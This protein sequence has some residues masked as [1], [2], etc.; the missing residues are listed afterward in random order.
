M[1][2]YRVRSSTGDTAEV[3]EISKGHFYLSFAGNGQIISPIVDAELV[4]GQ[5]T[6]LSYPNYFAKHSLTEIENTQQIT[7][8]KVPCGFS[9]YAKQLE[10]EET[11]TI[12]TMI[13]H[14]SDIEIINRQKDILAT[15]E[16]F[17][18]KYQEA[19]ELV[20]DITKG[21]ETKTGVP[22]FDAYT[23]QSYLDNILRGGYPIFLSDNE[24]PFVYYVYSRK[25]GDLERDYNFFFISPEFFSQGN[26][27]FRD[28]N[29]N[30]RNDNFFNPK[31]GN[32]NI[33]LFMN[34]IQADGY[35][36][37]VVKGASFEIMNKAGLVLAF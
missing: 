8:N 11:I 34:L 22:L 19:N 26:G 13:G 1:P 17:T 37:L 35:N 25:H 27:N 14:V 29:Q 10:G 28:V 15:S 31:V 33:K 18:K 30:R 23:K 2:Y 20:A 32:Y 5:N 12:S 24:N 6:S 4:F 9:G 21:I 7:A 36:P 16:Y 3:E